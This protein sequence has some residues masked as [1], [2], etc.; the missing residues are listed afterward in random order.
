[1]PS[2]LSLAQLGAMW[3]ALALA[4]IVFA[5]AGFGTALVAAP[6]LAQS[7]PLAQIVPLLALLDFCA[8]VGNLA[9]DGRQAERAE[10][11]RLLPCMLL[12]SGIGAALLLR[13]EAHAL[14][15]LLGLFAVA[16]ALYGLSGYKPARRFGRAAAVPFGLAGGVCSA[17]F[18]SGGFL[19]AI[20]LGG[21]LEQPQQ[22]RVTQSA[23]IGASTL[24]RL[25]MFVL[26]GVYAEPGLLPL[27]AL[28]ASAMLSG[29]AIGR[30]ITLTLPRAQFIRLVNGAVLLAG[31]FL[32]RRY[33]S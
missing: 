22:I 7:L 10:L 8:A 18:G 27:A 9:R 15:L 19:Y 21:R 28:L 1:M 5:I 25:I 26:A 31:I 29:L 11:G 3:L 4:Y 14:L 23:V 33:F 24:I 17:L 13:G 16:Y 32:L 20:Y 2:D 30:R 12:G 6:V